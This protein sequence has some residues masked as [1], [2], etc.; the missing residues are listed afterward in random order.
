MIDHSGTTMTRPDMKTTCDA[1]L[2]GRIEACQP[3]NGPRAAIDA[4]FLAAAVP[5][6]NSAGE[7]ALEAGLGSG[8]ASLALAARVPTVRITG[9]EI[10][11]ELGELARRNVALNRFDDR[12]KVVEGDV[13]A[14]D[15]QWSASGIE[16]ESFSHVFANPP[17]YQGA[18][19]RVSPDR[20]IAR[21]HAG[22]AE[23]LAQWVR[24]LHRMAAPRG[25]ITIIH[26]ADALAE[27]TGLLQGRFG[28]LRVFPLFPKADQPASRVV[29]QGI[30]GSRAPLKLS[31]GLVLHDL[32]G[33]YTAEANVILRDGEGLV[34]A[35]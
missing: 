1:F 14:V 2:D 16:P 29:V 12:I 17:Y 13:T 25:S 32:Q 22:D 15:W 30:K 7:T 33:N 23:T 6:K 27:L 19:T 24:F 20:M 31:R 34:I 9:V 4:L 26:R 5:A 35:R 28:S 10:Q 8:V 11:P 21:A 3:V 18:N